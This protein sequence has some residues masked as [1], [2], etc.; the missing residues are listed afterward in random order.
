MNHPSLFS[1]HLQ[2][3]PPPYLRNERYR[4]DQGRPSS[5]GHSCTDE[6]AETYRCCWRGWPR[7]PSSARQRAGSSTSGGAKASSTASGSA[8]TSS[9]TSSTTD[10]VTYATQQVAKYEA[11]VTSYPAPGP[12][13]DAQKVAALKGKTVLFVPDGL[14]GPFVLAQQAV[15]TALSHVG[16]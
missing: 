16:I 4:D 10:G 12:A 11:A 2:P 9:S 7:S 6:A 8:S 5:Y 14:V 15:Q 13:L 1:S 3:P